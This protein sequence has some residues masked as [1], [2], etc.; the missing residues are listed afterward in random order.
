[1]TVIAA[2]EGGTSPAPADLDARWA[3]VLPHYERLRRIATRRLS[4]RDEVEDV[5]QE[6]MLRAVTFDRLDPA[7]VGQFLSTVTVRLCADVQRDRVRQLRVGVRDALRSVESPDPND[8]VLDRAEARWLY[9]ECLKLPPRESAVVLAR[10]SGMSVKETAVSL[11]VGTKSAEAALTKAR[12]RMRR[13]AQSAGLTA[14]G[15]LRRLRLAGTPAAVA[16][17]VTAV[18]V[19]G[20]MGGVVVR[21]GDGPSATVAAAPPAGGIVERVTAPVGDV[22]RVVPPPATV[23]RVV[24]T[25]RHAAPVDVA[26]APKPVTNP[27]DAPEIETAPVGDP[28]T[29]GTRD[30]VKAGEQRDEP[31]EETVARCVDEILTVD[32]THPLCDPEE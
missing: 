32:P 22:A 23:Q 13:A 10:A 20:V 12:H 2:T 27:H 6:A 16:A 29:V 30:G 15:V 17:T 19:G 25:V 24:R 8:T 26:P 7:Y 9:G 21:H 3:L 5:V 31:F 14:L 18:T 11:G 4:C 1:M 28:D